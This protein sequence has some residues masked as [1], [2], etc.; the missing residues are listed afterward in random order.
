VIELTTLNNYVLAL[1]VLYTEIRRKVFPNSPK[2]NISKQQI[3]FKRSA[4][5]FQ[6]AMTYAQLLEEFLLDPKFAP[7]TRKN[8]AIIL[9]GFIRFFPEK[10]LKEITGRD[11]LRYLVIKIRRLTGYPFFTSTIVTWAA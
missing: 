1:K 7:S 6:C 3:N 9:R 8:Y 11:L 4:R 5:M 2:F 10:L